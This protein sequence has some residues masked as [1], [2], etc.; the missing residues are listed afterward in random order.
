MSTRDTAPVADA[1]WD[2]LV[3]NVHVLPLK[4]PSVRKKKGLVV[5]N[6]VELG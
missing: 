1:I 5:K 4:G 6:T 2:R 3:H